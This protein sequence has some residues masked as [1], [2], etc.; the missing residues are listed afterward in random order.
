MSYPIIKGGYIEDTDISLSVI[1]SMSNRTLTD[2]FLDI[3]SILDFGIIDDPDDQYSQQNSI[4]Y[5]NAIAQ[6]SGKY[7]LHHPKHITVH[8]DSLDIQYPIHLILDGTIRL[9]QNTNKNVINLL[10]NDIS[11]TGTGIV[12]GNNFSDDGITRNQQGGVGTVLG[13]ICSNTNETN[14]ATIINPINPINISNILISGITITNCA[15]WPISLGYIEN[16]IVEKCTMNNSYSSPQFIFSAKNSWIINC[17]IYNIS[18]G[19][20]VFYQGNINCGAYGNVV[21]GCHDGIGVYNDY[22]S[23]S[24]DY[25]IIISNNIIYANKD[26]GIGI[27]T[28]GTNPSLNQNRILISNNICHHNNTGGTNGLGSIGVVGSESVTIVNNKIY[29]D[30]NIDPNTSINYQSGSTTTVGNMTYSITVDG[31]SR[32]IIIENN[33]ISD[34]GNATQGGRAIVVNST[35]FV[36]INNNK[37]YDTGDIITANAIYGTFGNNCSISNNYIMYGLST[38]MT[39]STDTIYRPLKK[40][41]YK[42]PITSNNQSSFSFSFGDPSNIDVYLNG[43]MLDPTSAYTCSNGNN[44]T[45]SNDIATNITT[46]DILY[47]ILN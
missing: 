35:N 45:L 47:F 27:T 23:M 13:G 22:S 18:D 31:S 38:V 29:S 8:V 34:V 30:G 46:T 10:S 5:L 42:A 11:I 28:G 21:Y 25:N 15:N 19:G 26:S 39:F 36:V 12:N 9:S 6:C 40:I 3:V 32:N 24:G 7:R 1:S 17:T 44:I 16:C 43:I 2:K 33:D 4:S 41:K 20:F 37:I 14:S